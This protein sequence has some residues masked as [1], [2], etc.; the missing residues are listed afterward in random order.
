MASLWCSL[1]KW[2]HVRDTEVIRQ[3]TERSAAI[4]GRIP[5]VLSA[6]A[7][8]SK[9]ATLH[10]PPASSRA[11]QRVADLLPTG[12]RSASSIYSLAGLAQVQDTQIAHGGR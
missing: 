3:R 7:L 8:I 12:S 4:K 10:Q 1:I 9:R 11:T 5:I 6:T 2:I